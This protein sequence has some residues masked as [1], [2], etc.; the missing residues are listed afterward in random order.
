VRITER[1]TDNSNNVQAVMPTGGGSTATVPN[2]TTGNI[3]TQTSFLAG[4]SMSSVNFP[5]ATIA[6]WCTTEDDDCQSSSAARVSTNHIQLPEGKTSLTARTLQV[7]AR[8]Q[9]EAASHRVLTTTSVTG[10]VEQRSTT[11]ESRVTS[12]VTIGNL[13][14]WGSTAFVA[15]PRY[16]GTVIIDQLQLTVLSIAGSSSSANSVV[17]RIDNLRVWDPNKLNADGTIGGYGTS[18]TFGFDSSCGQWIS[19]PA[20]CGPPM[21]NPNP[22]VIPAAYSGVSGGQAA[23]SLSIVTGATVQERT[24]DP[25]QGIGS[26]NTSQKSVITITTRED[27]TGAAA[28]EP[29]ITTLGSATATVSYVKHVH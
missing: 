16:E 7:N 13:K 1:R 22:V 8:D 12:T 14:V 28:L 20:G 29:S 23:T 2:S 15:N 21:E 17:W 3:Q 18:Y 4:G 5:S 26:A 9:L 24:S 25:G 27:V 19:N 11:N 10:D 6:S